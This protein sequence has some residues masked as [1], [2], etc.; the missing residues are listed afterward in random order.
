MPT[1]PEDAP[2][3]ELYEL[4]QWLG[5]IEIESVI[6]QVGNFLGERIHCSR[7]EEPNMVRISILKTDAAW[8]SNLDS[9][10]RLENPMAFEQC[11]WPGENVFENMRYV[12]LID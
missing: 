6:G 9:A 4:E 10:T 12:D 1:E 5:R 7:P 8:H 11:V 3:F 2:D